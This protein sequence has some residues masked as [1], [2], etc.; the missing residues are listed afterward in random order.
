MGSSK[1]NPAMQPRN[2]NPGIKTDI[3]ASFFIVRIFQNQPTNTIGTVKYLTI[4][5]NP[6]K[7]RMVR[8]IIPGYMNAN[9]SPHTEKRCGKIKERP[10]K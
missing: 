8:K 9:R 10:L 5:A 4:E 1:T 6:K 2:I 7:D 3:S